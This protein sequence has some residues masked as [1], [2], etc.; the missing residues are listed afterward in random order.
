MTFFSSSDWVA[1]FDCITSQHLFVYRHKSRGMADVSFNTVN[2]VY[3]VYMLLDPI[4]S[5]HH[6]SY[7]THCTCMTLIMKEIDK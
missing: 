2:I 4:C 6:G 5:H 1:A 3:C 7:C